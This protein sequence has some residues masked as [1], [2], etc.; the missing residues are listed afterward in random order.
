VS[1]L[2]NGVRCQRLACTQLPTERRR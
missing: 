1:A 2:A